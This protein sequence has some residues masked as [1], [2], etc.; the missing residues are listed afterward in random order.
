[1]SPTM[2]KNYVA[3]NDSK[4]ELQDQLLPFQE[5]TPK[6]T[7]GKLNKTF[8]EVGAAITPPAAL[9]NLTYD[10][11]DFVY[12]GFIIILT[13]FFIKFVNQNLWNRYEVLKGRPA[14]QILMTLL[15]GLIILFTISFVSVV[16]F[17]KS[18][19]S[20]VT[21]GGIAGVG[22]AFALQGP[23][24][25]FF[26]GIMMDIEGRISNGDW[27]R[28]SSGEE[29][30]VI[31]HNWRS[32]TLMTINNTIIVLS[33]SRLS[34]EM[35]EN[36]T[37]LGAFWESIDVTLDQ[38]IPI[39]RARRIIL[40]A[41]M[42]APGV[43]EHKATVNVFKF[44]EGGVVY[45]CKFMMT[46]YALKYSTRHNVMQAIM[47]A[48]HSYKINISE[49]LGEYIISER[50]NVKPSYVSLDDTSLILDILKK[51]PIIKDLGTENLEQFNTKDFIEYH[52]P[53]DLIVQ[54]GDLGDAMYV[55][56]EGVVQVSILDTSIKE[57]INV[58]TLGSADY[59]GEMAL[60]MGDTRRASIY[61]VTTVALLKIERAPIVAIMKDNPTL[62]E[63]IG[64]KI[65][66][67]LDNNRTLLESIQ[68]KEETPM[69]P[70]L[71]AVC[72]HIMKVFGI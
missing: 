1:M 24:L 67:H 45:T 22:F 72:R 36:M 31:G 10:A 46:N 21:A 13:F 19:W 41:M 3:D 33:N 37:S 6:E 5:S 30:R 18:L 60:F 11:S 71:I 32:T 68:N 23:I 7:N 25:D 42:Q 55:I 12:T 34:Q 47:Q 28:L 59:F 54:E 70:L 20:L 43:H 64:Q 69:P 4:K 63:A 49:I 44:T 38:N 57:Q 51:T 65:I 48:L 29:G 26:S 40:S 2:I 27:V 39:E 53:N 62:I 52:N 35:Y 16:I 50:K 66:D 58:A 9:K 15:N 56:L 61:A 8:H 17:E 14:P